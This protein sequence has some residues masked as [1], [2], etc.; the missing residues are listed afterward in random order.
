MK[1]T[2]VIMLAV[3]PLMFGMTG[4]LIIPTPHG[5]SGYARTN[6][7]QH[8]REQFMPGKTTRQDVIMALGEPDA[9]SWDE[10]QLAYR[11]EKVV[12]LWVLAV[13][14]PE[15]GGAATGGTIYKNHFYV[16]EFDP[17]GLYQTN[18]QTGQ[19][20]VVVGTDEPQLRSPMFI[21]GDS[22]GP[23]ATVVG[24]PVQRAYPKCFWLAGV[25]GYRSKGATYVAGELGHLF[26]TESNLAFATESQF[27]SGEPALKL[28]FASITEVHVDKYF[29]GRRLVVRLDSGA[30]H[31][32]EI[33][34]PGS[35]FLDKPGM[36]A[37]CDFIQSKIKPTPPKP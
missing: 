13:G 21:S 12:A 18:R 32:F 30:V 4:C 7:N 28:P 33:I 2:L 11:S 24:E 14:A 9:V 19:L 17:K 3:V 8:V 16:F 35:V 15:A 6:V 29:R 10:H 31:S 5:D 20:G 37:A 1:M 36:Q 27:Y 23:P 22:N 25:D 34:K 26:L